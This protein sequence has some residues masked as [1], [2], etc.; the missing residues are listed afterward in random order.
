[1]SNIS[2]I[3]PK[4]EWKIHNLSS[5]LFLNAN[6]Y[7]V[8]D[9]LGNGVIVDAPL[10]KDVKKSVKK[11]RELGVLPRNVSHIVITHAH[12]D[13]C[14][15]LKEFKKSLPNAKV[16][17][18]ELEKEDLVN[19]V[20]RLPRYPFFLSLVAPLLPKYQGVKADVVFSKKFMINEYVGVFHTPGHTKG[21]SSVVVLP[22]SIALVGDLMC[23]N[24]WAKA[25]GK[26]TPWL[27]EDF[28]LMKQGWVYLVKETGCNTFYP[29]HGPM[30]KLRD[31]FI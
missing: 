4:P 11:I 16:V 24:I 15:G 26:H 20:T 9:S 25:T 22:S 31:L 10:V 21:S 17:I 13:H 12:F 7:L 14:A 8:K 27:Y 5:G 6:V 29:G 2:S 28:A 23:N 19:G 1:M 30:L 18:Q 3:K